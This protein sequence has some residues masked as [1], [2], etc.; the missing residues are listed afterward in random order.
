MHLSPN[1]LL[2]L[3]I[4]LKA[5]MENAQWPPHLWWLLVEVGSVQIEQA[6]RFGRVSQDVKVFLCLLE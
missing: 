5:G 3:I 6:L 1:K 2:A 4:L